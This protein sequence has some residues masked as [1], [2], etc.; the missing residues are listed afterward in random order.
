MDKVLIT[1]DDITFAQILERYLS[2]HGYEVVLTHNVEQAKT[3]LNKDKGFKAMLLDYRLPDGNGLDLLDFKVQHNIKI[4][5]IMMTSFNDVKVA[6][7]CI[8]KGAYEYITKP[9]NQEE[10]LM[11]L[12]NAGTPEPLVAREEPEKVEETKKESK[13]A[14]VKGTSDAAQVLH[15]HVALVAQTEMSVLINGESGTG[16][17]HIARAL[18]D[19]SKRAS[20]PFIAVDCGA[21]SSELAASELFGHVKG[22]FTGAI[23]DKTGIFELANGG[24]IFLDEVGNL[25]YDVQVKLLRAI[26]QREVVPV[27]SHKVI[28]VDV[29]LVTATNED[30]KSAIQSASFR[31]D[32][33]HRINEFKIKIPALRERREDIDEF[34]R[35]FIQKSNQEL[36]KNVRGIDTD[37]RKI[38][39]QYHWPGNIRE[40]KNIIK[41]AVLLAQGD[42]ITRLELPED[43]ELTLMEQELE[44]TADLKAVQQQTEKELIIKTLAE[45]KYNKSKAAKL[46]N[47]DRTTLYNK[48][49]KYGIEDV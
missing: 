17:E 2:R 33:Y 29:R 28:K 5:V 1:E 18:H 39:M 46:L 20:K 19:R 27:G 7:Q 47:I 14:F 9:I 4:P 40:L 8:K 16:K 12:K 11:L 48:L 25:S 31:E 36:Q 45:T 13:D 6:V 44:P 41:R 35:Y 23:I 3:A 32:L 10:L 24:T 30:F 42:L 22:A 34:I 38:F 43:M 49:A 21:L 37:V 26:E 15:Q